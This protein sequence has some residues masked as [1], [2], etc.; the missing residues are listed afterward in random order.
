MTS[1]CTPPMTSHHVRKRFLPNS[2]LNLWRKKML[3]KIIWKTQNFEK[4]KISCLLQETKSWIYYG[5]ITKNQNGILKTYSNLWP[6]GSAAGN[7]NH[8]FA[9]RANQWP[10]PG[11]NI[12]VFRNSFLPTTPSRTLEELFELTRRPSRTLILASC[13]A[14][15]A[16]E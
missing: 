14:F 12:E 4:M 9:R 16:T 1:L 15:G 7:K 3:V 2:A 8:W 10:V 5:K 6:S 11:K 13:V